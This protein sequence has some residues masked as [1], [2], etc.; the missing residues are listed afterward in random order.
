[1]SVVRLVSWKPELAR[2]RVRILKDA[3]VRVDSSPLNTGGLIGQFRSNMVLRWEYIPGS[4]VFLVWTQERNGSFYDSDPDHNRYSFE[5]AEKTHNIFL[6][7][8]TYRFRL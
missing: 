6:I 2:E 1:M 8:Y 7:K 3:G 4:T 5:F